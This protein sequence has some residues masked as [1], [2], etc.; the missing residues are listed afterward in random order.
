MKRH[1]VISALMVLAPVLMMAQQGG[2]E[3]SGA[4]QQVLLTAE[5]CVQLGLQNN[6]DVRN[7]ELDVVGARLQKQ[8]ALAE[9]FPSIS[10]MGLAFHSLSP[11]IDIS[12]TDVLG[13]SDMAWYIQDRLQEM[14]A[15]YD[16]RT[17]YR[18]LNHGYSASLTLTQPVFAG[19]RIISGN[20]LAALG[21]EAA[22]VKRSLQKRQSVEQ[23]QKSFYQVL[24][25]QEKQA[26]LL[27]ASRLLD[28]LYK[29]VS[30][31]CEAGLALQ[32]DLSAVSIKQAE[33]KAGQSKL[34]LGLRVAKMNLLN[35]IGMEYNPYPGIV[36]DG[37]RP[38][39]DD[40][41][42]EGSFADVMS[43][44]KAYVDEG[45]VAAELDEARLLQM[46]VDAKVLERRMT[47][48]AALPSVVF[49]ASY[50]YSRMLTSPK[51]NG[52][53]YAV[54]QIPITDWGKNSRKLERQ[55][56]EVQK[57]ENQRDFY[58][59][60]LVLQ[61]RQLYMELCSAWDQMQ[62]AR[63]SEVLATKRLSQLRVSYEAGLSTLTELLQSELEHR[64]A[65]ESYIDAGLDYLS[66]LE[67]YR[68][69]IQR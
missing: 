18:A 54:L 52:A 23:I 69:R 47:L 4:S 22:D 60:Q 33:L 40:F 5:S 61:V 38:S 31:A 53:M 64:S 7:A 24:A 29:D 48:G 21:V 1:F 17:R 37:G 26:S 42:L 67:S 6:V 58:Q 63:E 14:A 50:G 44:D 41:V 20:R 2:A 56:L 34:R 10:A 36:D 65:Q 30:A 68:L 32:T 19:G 35:N 59:G 49:G 15:P 16:I 57:A 12:I 8:E 46:Q 13:T 39:I 51:A 45:K 11:L 62:I 28:S 3:L 9:Y 66:A 27:V 55:R 25:L 43:P